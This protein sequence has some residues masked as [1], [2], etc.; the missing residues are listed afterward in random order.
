MRK[1]RADLARIAAAPFPS[2]Y[3]K[4]RMREQVE[5]LAGRGVPDV[6]ALVEHDGDIIWPSQEVRS[7]V[8]SEQRALAFATAPDGLALVAFLCKP[9]LI[10]AL[11]REIDAECEDPAALT[12]EQRQLRTDEIQRDLLAVEMEEGALVWSAQAQGLPIEFRADIDP[13]AVLQV[14]LVKVQRAAIGPS[15]SA[16]VFDVVHPGR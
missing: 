2:G 7:E 8:Y 16:L 11:G 1:L 4:A 9:A 14:A 5:I 12:H 3:C 6:T 13:R 10:A 15:T